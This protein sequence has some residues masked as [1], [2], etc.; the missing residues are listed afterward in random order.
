MEFFFLLSTKLFSLF[1]IIVLGYFAGRFLEIEAKP[2]ARLLI[3]IFGPIVFFDAIL[4]AQLRPQELLLPFMFLGMCSLLCFSFFK[5]GASFYREPT[6]NI[7]AFTA[8]SANTGYFGIPAIIFI[9]GEPYLGKAIL[10]IFGYNLFE[11]SVGYY[12]TARGHFSHKEAFLKVIRLPSLHA[13]FMAVILNFMGW[14]L[15]SLLQPIADGAKGAYSLLGLM[16]VGIGA[17]K[18]TKAHIDWVFVGLTFVAKF[19][20][21]PIL[22]F[23]MIY[24]DKNVTHLFD[25]DIYKILKLLS[26]VPLAANGV[27]VATEL[28]A[29]PEKVSLAILLSTLFALFYIPLFVIFLF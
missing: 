6:K 13:F 14:K 15:P 20:C 8:G 26:V 21:F 17:S 9:L 1:G 12:I 7:L 24:V 4:K 19:I 16:I 28:K 18:I 5:I 29:N 23:T 2:L 11:N 25:A 27:A 3:Y 10:A 22:I